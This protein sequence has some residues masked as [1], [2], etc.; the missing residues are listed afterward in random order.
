LYEDQATNSLL[1]SRQYT[2][3]SIGY[4][5]TRSRCAY[6]VLG[7]GGGGGLVTGYLGLAPARCRHEY[8][9]ENILPPRAPGARRGY[10][11]AA[12]IVA[13]FAC[14]GRYGGRVRAF[15]LSLEV[16]KMEGCRRLDSGPD[17]KHGYVSNRGCCR[18]WVGRYL[19]T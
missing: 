19:G 4:G 9:F 16:Q 2:Q 18:V 5:G 8:A 15:L 14:L 7:G 17:A 3:P 10:R 13:L 11:V 12:N 6:V 1:Y